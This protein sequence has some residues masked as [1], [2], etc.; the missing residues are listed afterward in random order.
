MAAVAS[1]HHMDGGRTSPG[2]G[3]HSPNFQDGLAS[4]GPDGKRSFKEKLLDKIADAEVHDAAHAE[5][6]MQDKKHLLVSMLVDGH[7]QSFVDFFYLTHRDGV[8]DDI[9]TA[10]ELEARGMDPNTQDLPQDEV[11]PESLHFLKENLVLADAASRR[12]DRRTM[13]EAFQNLARHFEEIDNPKK[14]I[15]F[16]KKCLGVAEQ[17]GDLVGMLQANLNLGLAHEK[18]GDLQTAMAY[19]EMHL[20]LARD[21]GGAEM[22]ADVHTANRNLVQAYRRYAEEQERLGDIPK[23]IEFLEMCMARAESGDDKGAL[24]M[25]NHRLGLAYDKLGDGPRAVEYHNEYL[26]IC[27]ATGDKAGEGAACCAL[28]AAH[29]AMGDVEQAVAN[30][31]SFLELAKVG[32]PTSQAQACCSLG[33]IYQQ[34]GNFDRAVMYFEKFFEVARSL[35]DRRMLDVARVNLGVARGSAH[36]A[37][38]IDV[39]NEDLGMLLQWKNVRTPFDK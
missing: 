5:L 19:H 27:V 6:A 28:A 21:E 1:P 2:A 20:G 10:A 9:P 26:R 8:M 22:E 12:G 17:S 33:V 18:A 14:C 36:T 32:D 35:N 11:P 13:Y 4:P 16:H 29:Q 31:E 38:Y 25:A 39:V 7:P 34:Q 37:K 3:A 23:S 15:F 24:G 30:L